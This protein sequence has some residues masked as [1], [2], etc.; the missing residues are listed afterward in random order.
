VS[1]RLKKSLRTLRPI[2][3]NKGRG[4]YFAF[5]LNGIETLF[6]VRPD[7]EGK[8]MLKVRG[9]KGEFVVS[10]MLAVIREKGEGFYSYSWSKPNKQ[11]YFPKIA[12]VKL[13]EPIGW[14]IGTGEYLDDV[15]KDIQEECLKW[16]SNI[17]FGK[18]GYVFAG[19]WDGLSLSGPAT[20]KNMYAVADING[21]KIVQELI[22]AAKSEGG[23]FTTFFQN[24]K[25]KNMPLR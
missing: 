4:Y 7:M 14:V 12:F 19:Q 11:G 24:S 3:F 17:K 15:E 10:D 8:N 25:G 18:D 6:P 9:G 23:F 1:K 16:I 2:R 20:G 21:V 5:D 22:K 13:F